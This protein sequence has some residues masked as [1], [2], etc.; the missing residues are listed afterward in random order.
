MQ[1]PVF[2]DAN[3]L[4]E[5]VRG[6]IRD[7]ILDEL[8]PK[9]VV[10]ANLQCVGFYGIAQ[11]PGDQVEIDVLN[12]SSPHATVAHELGHSL[13]LQHIPDDGDQSL[14]MHPTIG[15]YITPTECSAARAH[16]MQYHDR[17]RAYN[18][19]RGKASVPIYTTDGVSNNIGGV[20]IPSLVCCATEK[21]VYWMEYANICTGYGDTIVAKENCS[22]C[23]LN[24][25][26]T[27]SLVEECTGTLRPKSDCTKVCCGTADFYTE[28][29]NC[30][31]AGIPII[32]CP[33]VH[34]K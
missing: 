3:Q 11:I 31:Q 21:N 19:K 9:F 33:P 6:Q 13:G 28:K 2:L 26:G 15:S 23:C 34:P 10:F 22:K 18:I 24:S 20:G 32:E 12:E 1:Q 27:V 17:F 14:L 7:D 29:Y 30:L 4:R 25:N 16:A 8:R 5:K